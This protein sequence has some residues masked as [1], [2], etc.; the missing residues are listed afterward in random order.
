[1]PLEHEHDGLRASEMSTAPHVYLTALRTAAEHPFRLQLSVG[2]RRYPARARLYRK[3]YQGK[4]VVPRRY[5][6]SS[7]SLNVDVLLPACTSTLLQMQDQF[8]TS[9]CTEL[10][11]GRTRNKI[12]SSIHSCSTSS[13]WSLNSE[14]IGLQARNVFP[15]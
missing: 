10:Y 6:G 1:M 7:R 14:P 8:N 2:S 12:T 5:G 4:L 9:H 3:K 15:T 13:I 11:G